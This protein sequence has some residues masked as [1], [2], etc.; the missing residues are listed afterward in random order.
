VPCLGFDTFTRLLT[1]V[2]FPRMTPPP[3][4]TGRLASVPV[5]YCELSLFSPSFLCTHARFSLLV[6]V[7]RSSFF[8]IF[9]FALTFPSYHF[10]LYD[11]PHPRPQHGILR[12]IN[13]WPF[14]LSHLSQELCLPRSCVYPF[15]PGGTVLRGF[16]L[17]GVC[18]FLGQVF[19]VIIS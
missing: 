3:Y 17:I 19:V 9:F 10:L 14:W 5:F 16:L 2:F 12:R 11:R 4:F 18:L 8:Y 15:K 1:F 7:L 13:R 6:S